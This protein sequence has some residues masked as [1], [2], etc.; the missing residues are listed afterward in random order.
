M[1]KQNVTAVIL[2]G[3]R[4]RRMGGLDKGLIDFAGKPMIEHILAAIT[5]QCDAVIINANRNVE[6]YI[7]YDHPVLTDELNDYQGPLAGFAIALEHA[8]TP[9]I[10]TVPCDAPVI[11]NDLVNRLFST[12]QS[13]NA[14]IAV[15]HDGDR[16]QPVYALI[17]KELTTS[18]KEFLDS[19]DRKID[20]W[21]ALNRTVY[22][23]F[24][25]IPQIFQNINTPEQQNL[26][27]K[28]AIA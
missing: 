28:E 7:A 11:P 2:A 1:D 24:S 8:T 18:L 13:S 17:K 14:D 12:M 20:R 10:V 23:D 21:Y 19:G 4:G 27:H 3:G 22:A 26:L 5:P 25:D 9:L 6:R 16:L 15:A